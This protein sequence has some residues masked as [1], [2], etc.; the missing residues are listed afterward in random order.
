MR[1]KLS[2]AWKNYGFVFIFAAIFLFYVLVSTGLTWG[3]VTNIL[4][5]SA[6]IGI[7][8]LGAGLVIITGEIDLSVGSVVAFVAGF[9]VCVF[10]L[11]GS[12]VRTLLFCLVCGGLGGLV[13]GILVGAAKMPS[14]IVTLATMLIYR[15]LSQ[16]FCQQLG[17]AVTGGGNS[18]F[19]MLREHPSYQGLFDFGN[20]KLLTIPNVGW[21]VVIFTLLCVCL[22]T[23]TKFGKKLYAIGSN[24]KAARLAGIHV[25]ANRTAV[26]V[27]SG[28]LSGL[29][30]FLWI[31]M[32]G[33]CDP[34]TTG[35]SFEMYAIA[36]VVLGGISMSGGKGRTLGIL[37]GALSYTIIDKII[38]ALK[39]H[40]LI[41]DTIKGVILIA[42]IL[43]QTAGPQLKKR[44]PRHK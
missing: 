18:L 36:A 32:N 5:H 2:S 20:G 17:A 21:I 4:R 43:V 26:F 7:V 19:K 3:G 15:S 33:S 42:A 35:G 41:N 34:A 9:A 27:I 31:A 1:K 30:A 8:A 29:G 11:T 38:V 25:S 10:N 14:F 28:I 24:E 16:Y 44:L 39:M 37:F 22:S 6:V 13:N 12:G 23:S 40:S